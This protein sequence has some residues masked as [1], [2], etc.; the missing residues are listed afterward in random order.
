M[1]KYEK[2]HFLLEYQIEYL[3]K[4]WDELINKF[5]SS[6]FDK[7]VRD[8]DEFKRLYDLFRPN[9]I[10]QHHHYHGTVKLMDAIYDTFAS[11]FKIGYNKHFS[12]F[13]RSWIDQIFK[14]EQNFSEVD[15]KYLIS[16][17]NYIKN[18]INGTIFDLAIKS[19]PY[20]EKHYSYHYSHLI[21]DY[22]KLRYVFDDD[23]QMIKNINPGKIKIND[24]EYRFDRSHK[25]FQILNDNNYKRITYNIS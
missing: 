16:D 4:D 11:V 21:Y 6:P 9:T 22:L 18:S 10:T 5:I 8:V 20:F 3:K 14:K 23:D 25:L 7:L 24:K 17:L 12:K 1:R 15:W 13:G 19:Y 2:K